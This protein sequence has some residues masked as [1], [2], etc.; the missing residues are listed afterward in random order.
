MNKFQRYRLNH[1]ERVKEIQQAYYDRDPGRR[2]EQWR[3]FA[4]KKT[5][6]MSPEER[7]ASRLKKAEYDKAYREKNWDERASYK[8]DPERRKKWLAAWKERRHQFRLANPLPPLLTP[9]QKK[10]RIRKYREE[11]KEWITAWMKEYGKDYYVKNRSKILKQTGIRAK[12]RR[13][14]DPWFAIKV[15]LR[16]RVHRLIR[17]K[18]SKSRKAIELLGCDRDFFLKHLESQFTE[19]MTWQNYGMHGWHVD[20]KKPCAAFNLLE[21][22]EQKECFH[23]SNLQP[24][25]AKDNLSKSSRFE[26]VRRLFNKPVSACPATSSV[27]PLT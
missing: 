7:E 19:G 24:L 6:S 15:S 1:P 14:T 20:H 23:Y 11:N 2:K 27:S 8:A 9:E 26:G 22:S 4:A 16:A 17:G 13:K 25:W 10:E 3:K 5:A 12:E 18:F 21:E